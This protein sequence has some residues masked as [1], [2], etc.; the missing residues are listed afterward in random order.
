MGHWTLRASWEGPCKKTEVLPWSLRW[1]PREALEQRRD[2]VCYHARLQI[3]FEG[4]IIRTFLGPT[5]SG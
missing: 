2:G 1:E 3:H 4:N 5:A